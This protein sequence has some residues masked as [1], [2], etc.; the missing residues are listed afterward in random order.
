MSL[1]LIVAIA[2][3]GVIG[4]ANQLPWHIPEDLRFFKQVTMGKPVIMGRK[5]YLSIGRPLPGRANFVV[6]GAAGWRVDGITAVPC[7]TEALALCPEGEVFVI[8]GRRL[9]EEALTAAQRLYI[10]EVHRAYEGDVC[11]PPW[12]REAWSET[13]RR[14]IEGDPP[15]SFVSWE[16]S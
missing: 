1:S 8:G 5:T 12:S 11:F 16:R 7:L 4:K 15:I 10:T 13:S 3:N 6:T 9:F 14:R 2:E